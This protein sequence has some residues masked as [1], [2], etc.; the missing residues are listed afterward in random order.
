M[1]L[2]GG[3]TLPI[4]A[5]DAPNQSTIMVRFLMVK[6]PSVYN[7]ILGRSVLNN[8]KAIISIYHLTIKFPTKGGGVGVVRGDQFEVRKCYAIAVKDKGKQKEAMHIASGAAPTP[9][10]TN[11]SEGAPFS[12]HIGT[13]PQDACL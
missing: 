11:P 1:Q 4:I 7:V 13:P 3:S 2:E 12:V 9:A 8:L 10:L 5:G 6:C